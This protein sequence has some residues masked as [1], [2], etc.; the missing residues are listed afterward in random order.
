[1]NDLQVLLER[2]RPTRIYTH[3][4]A[5]EHPDH[6]IVSYLVRDAVADVARYGSQFYPTVHAAVLHAP[7]QYPYEDK[8]ASTEYRVLPT[9]DYEADAV[10]PQPASD[11]SGTNRFTPDIAHTEPPYL[12]ATPFHWADR[13]Q[14]AVPFV[15]KTPILENNFKYLM[16]DAYASQH[17]PDGQV[18][19]FGKSEEIFWLA[20][21]P[22]NIAPL[23]DITASSENTA[24]FQ[25]AAN[26]ADGIA[27]GHPGNGQA[28]WV[29]I[30]ESA[31]AYVAFAW[32]RSH[33]VSRVVLHDRPNPD[34]QV[35]A[36][37]LRFSD[38]SVVAFGPL[39]NDGAATPVSFPSR[40]V[41]SLEVRITAVAAATTAIGLAEV[42]VF[43][44]EADPGN[45][46]PQFVR[47]PAASA[48]VLPP[49]G[50]ATVTVSVTEPEGDLLTILWEA[51]YGTITGDGNE[52][53][54]VA[55]VVSVPTVDIVTVAVWDGTTDPIE[56]QLAIRIEP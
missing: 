52:V 3:S 29:S 36:G 26:V 10:W 4:P 46:R 15:M 37:E 9:P 42:Q 18:F 44:V 55:P 31:G 34:D 53:T 8:W 51:D 2:Y 20:Y 22:G 19:A 17:D 49:S 40:S 25:G 41:D 33:D 45:Q 32:D 30:G 39:A 56:A 6:R 48:Y 47:G 12:S 50:T 1:V 24:G 54:Y 23:A 35:L 13:L 38:G 7:K 28:E 5:D 21:E 27:D 11:G 43:A 16:I 14:L